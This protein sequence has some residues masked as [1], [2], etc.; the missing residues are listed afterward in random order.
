VGADVRWTDIAVHHVGYVD[1]AVRTRK[2]A[3]DTRLL[4]QELADRP[5]DP[6][7]LFNLG[8]VLH[9]AGEWAEAVGVL[10][11]SLARSHPRDSIVRKLYALVAQCHSG[12]GEPGRAAAAVA[13]GREHYPDD[14]EL[15]FL[16]AG[17][18][19]EG[20]A[21][22]EA[23]GLYRRLLAGADGPHFGSVDAGLR[24]HKGMHN[25]A[26]VLLAA[27]RTGEADEWLRRAVDAEPGFGPSWAALG[28]RAARRGDR[29][30]AD[31]VIDRLR[32]LGPPWAADADRLAAG[33]DGS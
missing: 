6:F 21:W 9:E 28:D 17:L 18:A 8:A 32:Q 10:D 16:A 13:A 2:R 25:L 15:L 20:G 30:E 1:P 5:D 12:L 3:R 14:A 19:R 22:A 24:G 4:R 23:E 33:G 26:L 7:A 29:A 31:R 11:R 27:G